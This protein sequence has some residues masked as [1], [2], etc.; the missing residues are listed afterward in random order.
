MCIG[1]PEEPEIPQRRPAG[2]SLQIMA[3]EKPRRKKTNFSEATLLVI[4]HYYERI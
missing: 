1:S 4:A 2:A 3:R